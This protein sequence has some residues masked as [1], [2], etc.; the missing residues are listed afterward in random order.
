DPFRGE[1]GSR[2]YKTGDLGR[3]LADGTIEYLGR[4]D[5]QVKIRGYRIELGEIEAQLLRHPHVKNAVVLA[6]EEEPGEKRLVAYVVADLVRLKAAQQEKPEEAGAEVVSQWQ[7]LYEDTYSGSGAGP[8][9]VGW[10]SSYTGQ[11]I[12]EDQMQ[13]WLKGTVERVRSFGP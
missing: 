2:M 10:N 7:R 4:N 12:P 3:W 5:H 9:F 11:A 6:R 1:E 13:E 8:S